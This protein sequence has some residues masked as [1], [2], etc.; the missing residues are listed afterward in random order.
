MVS[1]SLKPNAPRTDLGTVVWALLDRRL[2]IM[3]VPLA[4][5]VRKFLASVKPNV[6]VGLSSSFHQ[7][8][9]HGAGPSRIAQMVPARANASGC[10]ISER[11]QDGATRTPTGHL[12]RI[13]LRLYPRKERAPSNTS[14]RSRPP[15]SAGGTAWTPTRNGPSPPASGCSNRMAQTSVAPMSTRSR[16]P[17]CA[18]F[19]DERESDHG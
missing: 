8:A 7:G 16:G 1:P 4:P 19:L 13:T 14:S 12:D 15:S 18:R 6:A 10:W 2:V 17:D 5:T 9:H 11:S 3:R